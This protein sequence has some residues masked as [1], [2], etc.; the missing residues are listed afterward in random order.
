[1]AI[2][3]RQL[4]FEALRD[5]P[6]VPHRFYTLAERFVVVTTPTLGKTRVSVRT[7]GQ[8]P[9]LLLVHGLMTTAYSGRSVVEPLA[10]R[11]TVYAVDLPGAGRTST[12][13]AAERFLEAVGPFLKRVPE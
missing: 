3:F 12:V 10:Q 5:A 13:D 1:M 7:T 9:P 6:R 11:F 8:G 2:P 4:A